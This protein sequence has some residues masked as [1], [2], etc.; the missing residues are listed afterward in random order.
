MLKKELIWSTDKN[1]LTDGRILAICKNK[2][3]DTYY[4]FRQ[5]LMEKFVF[6]K[7]DEEV[8]AYTYIEEPTKVLKDLTQ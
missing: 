4:G 6:E 1:K 3:N 8:L 2:H 5:I 7:D